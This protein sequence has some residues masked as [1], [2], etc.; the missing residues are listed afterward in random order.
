MSKL[1]HFAVPLTGMVRMTGDDKEDLIERIKNA[2]IGFR[3]DR[4][5]NPGMYLIWQ[6]SAL[7]IEQSPEHTLPVDWIFGA[8]VELQPTFEEEN[9]GGVTDDDDDDKG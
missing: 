5:G 4:E 3:S 2:R 9:F 6:G 8:P 7:E 1:K